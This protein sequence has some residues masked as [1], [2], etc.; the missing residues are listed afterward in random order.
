MKTIYLFLRWGTLYLLVIATVVA[1]IWE[2]SLP[3]P[4]LDHTLLLIGILGLSG[5]SI[6]SWITHHEANLLAPP[7]E[8][9]FFIEQRMDETSHPQ[10][11]IHLEKTK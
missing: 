2:N 3:V 6:N 4:S 5:I 7:T 1:C 9:K 10:N 11:E 8:D